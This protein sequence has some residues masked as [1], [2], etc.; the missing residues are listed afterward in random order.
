MRI[1]YN[2][3]DNGMKQN[4]FGDEMVPGLA[5][6]TI[7][8]PWRVVCSCE[9][10]KAGG[11]LCTHDV[12]LSSTN[13]DSRPRVDPVDKLPDTPIVHC[14]H[15]RGLKAVRPTKFWTPPKMDNYMSVGSS[16]GRE[17]EFS[18]LSSEDTGISS[19]RSHVSSQHQ[20]QNLSSVTSSQ[21]CSHS[22]TTPQLPLCDSQSTLQTTPR[23]SRE[24]IPVMAQARSGQ[25]R[26]KFYSPRKYSFTS[27]SKSNSGAHHAIASVPEDSGSIAK[28]TSA[29]TRNDR[30][31]RNILNCTWQASRSSPL[32]SLGSDRGGGGGQAVPEFL[33]WKKKWSRKND[34][35]KQ[36]HKSSST[37]LSTIAISSQNSP[38]LDEGATPFKPSAPSSMSS[39]SNNPFTTHATPAQDH[40][41]VPAFS[42]KGDSLSSSSA[43]Y[44]FKGNSFSRPCCAGPSPPRINGMMKLA[45]NNAS[46]IY[47]SVG[48]SFFDVRMSRDSSSNIY[49][50]TTIG[51]QLPPEVSS[52]SNSTS[53]HFSSSSSEYRWPWSPLKKDQS[54]V[55][56]F[57]SNSSSNNTN[58]HGQGP[59]QQQQQQ[60]SEEKRNLRQQRHH[61]TISADAVPKELDI[62]CGYQ[63]R[64]SKS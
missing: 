58:T 41:V 51:S 18:S 44:T 14:I 12:K 43:P 26:G 63:H 50:E 11:A 8:K 55:Q 34:V 33:L 60:K 9:N 39:S 61:A 42:G 27:L 54:S 17:A 10:G 64:N 25:V 57:G 45:Q 16:E 1:G 32:S 36:N 37:R 35:R 56:D 31:L 7:D 5:V 24:V 4:P 38:S 6:D 23:V 62:E 48:G 19:D 15:G 46:S 22:A 40:H 49:Q 21:S 59:Q 13:P 53:G 29:A 30:K 3:S 28:S 2:R 20:K 52:N 47:N